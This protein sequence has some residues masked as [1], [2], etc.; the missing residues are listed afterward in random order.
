VRARIRKEPSKGSKPATGSKEIKT[1]HWS[2]GAAVAGTAVGM[3][4]GAYIKAKHG[5]AAKRKAKKM[6]I[7]AVARQRRRRAKK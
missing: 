3:G 6:G 5:S 7:E 1:A 4:H 2:G